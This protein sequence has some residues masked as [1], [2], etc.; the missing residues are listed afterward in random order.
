[1]VVPAPATHFAHHV[2]VRQKV[3][4]NPSLAFALAGLTPATRNIEGK[5]SRFV[6]AFARL[7]QHGVEIANVCEDARVRRWIRP[8]G[9]ADRRL[10]N[11]NDFVHVFRAGNSLVLSSLF[12]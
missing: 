1:M 3:H 4:L 2:Y 10:V 9:T 12:P 11:A 8:R 6:A 7:R 5:P